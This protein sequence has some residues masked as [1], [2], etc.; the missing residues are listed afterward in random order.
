MRQGRGCK[1]PRGMPTETLN[2][3][4]PGR[5][6]LSREANARPN[7]TPRQASRGRRRMS[8]A[9][10]CRRRRAG[11]MLLELKEGCRRPA[12][13]SDVNGPRESAQVV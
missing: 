4:R 7:Q 1:S 12:A 5:T 10:R 8:P 3:G 9:L 2:Q 13:K 11:H 6:A